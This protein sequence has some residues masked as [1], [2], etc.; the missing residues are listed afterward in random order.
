MAK[1][2]AETTNIPEQVVIAQ[3]EDDLFLRRLMEGAKQEPEIWHADSLVIDEQFK[4]MFELPVELKK[5]TRQ[6]SQAKERSYCWVEVSDQR[7]AQTYI[8]DNWIPVNRDN[9]PFLP[10]HYFS[11]H[12]GIERNGYTK[13]ILFWQPKR[14]N[15]EVKKAAANRATTRLEDSKRA[16]ENLEGPVR[17]EEVSGSGGYG[18]TP[19]DPP[20]Q[21]DWQGNRVE[22]QPIEID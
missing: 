19:A 5:G 12:G 15:E 9:H 17:M 7:I 4:S 11:I 2:V 10:S 16:L 1:G 8:K 20:I 18:V 21:T 22:D 14:Y 3:S 6:A 13:H